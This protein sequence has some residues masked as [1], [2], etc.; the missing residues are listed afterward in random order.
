MHVK[1]SW[2]KNNT[3]GQ[4]DYSRALLIELVYVCCAVDDVIE[5]DFNQ[6]V[7]DYFGRLN[8]N[9]GVQKLLSVSNLITCN[10]PV[11]ARE[12]FDV[13]CKTYCKYY[14]S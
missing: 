4:L 2:T 3:D 5:H 9:A 8:L 10:L 11:D 12:H 1:E 6:L 13:V 7:T 14:A